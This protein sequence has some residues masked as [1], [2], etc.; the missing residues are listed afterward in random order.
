[1]RVTEKAGDKAFIK[2]DEFNAKTWWDQYPHPPG[3][4]N[5]DEFF[6]SYEHDKHLIRPLLVLDEKEVEIHRRFGVEAQNEDLLKGVCNELGSGRLLSELSFELVEMRLAKATTKM[7]KLKEQIEQA[8]GRVLTDSQVKLL[9]SIH[10]GEH[11]EQ[12]EEAFR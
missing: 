11:D 7:R 12:I 9:L 8:G 4:Q 1:M 2:R 10:R 6:A 3:F 5:L